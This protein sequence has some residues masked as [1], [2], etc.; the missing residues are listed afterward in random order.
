MTDSTATTGSDDEL[1]PVM[2]KP[3]QAEG[4]DVDVDAPEPQE[5]GNEAIGRPSQ[6]EGE[7]DSSSGE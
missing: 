5:D 4:E 2:D 1:D 7:D 3:S 6:A